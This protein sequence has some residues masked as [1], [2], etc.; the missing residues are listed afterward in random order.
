MEFLQRYGMATSVRTDWQ[1]YSGQT[2][3]LEGQCPS[4]MQKRNQ[5][6]AQTTAKEL[7]L[8]VNSN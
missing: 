4:Q 2:G 1:A 7:L 8:E 6:R 5:V 3:A